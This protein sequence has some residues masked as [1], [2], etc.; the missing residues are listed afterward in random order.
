MLR[1]VNGAR[2]QNAQ[3]ALGSIVLENGLVDLTYHGAIY[4][5]AQFS[6]N[7]VTFFASDLWEAEGSEVWVWSNQCTVDSCFFEHVDLRTVNTKSRV[8]TTD[9]TG[10]NAG[11]YAEESAFMVSD[12]AFENAMIQSENAMADFSVKRSVFLN[13]AYIYDNSLVN[14]FVE[15]CTFS[16]GNSHA[17][18]KAGGTLNLRCNQFNDIEGVYMH[19]GS[20]NMSSFNHAG[21]NFFHEVP[22]CVTC[23]EV[24][25]LQLM[26]GYNDF[27]GY[28]NYVIAGVMDTTCSLD[29]ACE[30]VLDA[31][32]NHWGGELGTSVISNEGGLFYPNS[33]MFDLHAMHT[34]ACN[35]YE[36]GTQCAIAF[37]DVSPIHIKEC[38][39]GFP[40]EERSF[41]LA[42]QQST[43][44]SDIH[45]N[46]D[47]LTISSHDVIR[48]CSIYDVLGRQI[49]T[50]RYD[51]IAD[52]EIHITMAADQ[53]SG[54][55]TLVV[56]TARGNEVHRG[57][58]E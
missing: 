48:A 58:Y 50:S 22:V 51:A 40:Q 46:G 29:D 34:T 10:P 14:A 19:Q 33:T 41:T 52:N 11:F 56:E 9:F 1:I 37:Q 18:E 31:H 17:I 49:A 47:Q 5:D 20:V 42:Q 26:R 57:F 4:T 8:N 16:D 55:Y 44:R 24:T 3:W 2:L 15:E 38:P 28:Q 43:A 35:S 32:Y 53:A 30:L 25:D 21:Y 12:C 27:S 23:D 36:S 13:D 39:A 7:G 6:A 54:Y 45:R